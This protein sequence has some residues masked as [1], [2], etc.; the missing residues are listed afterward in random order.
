MRLGCQR[1]GVGKRSE[2][3]EVEILKGQLSVIAGS[4]V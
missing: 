1:E 2:V 4:K 3:T